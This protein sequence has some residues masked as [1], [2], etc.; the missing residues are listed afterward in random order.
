MKQKDIKINGWAIEYRINA[1]DVQAGFSPSL[2]LIE[3]MSLPKS[4]HIRI[5][6]GV[7]EGSSIT[8]YF[9]SMVAKLIV[10]A[11][12]REKAIGYSLNALNK[13][14][15]KGLKTTIPFCKAVLLNKKF[16]KGK[17]DTSFLTKEMKKH[18]HEEPEDE[19]LAAFF[20]TYDF[21]REIENEEKKEVDFDKGKNIAPWV[22]KK[23]LKSL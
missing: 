21:V 16:R 13:F 10:H 8:P 20:A 18:Y 3:K 4:K 9:D 2:G 17:Y 19:M 11:D 1:E 7:V 6:T 5:D 14:R 23:R 22:L 12:T 15:I